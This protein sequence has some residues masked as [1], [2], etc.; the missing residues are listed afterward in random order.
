MSK[1][2]P[3]VVSSEV[4]N[5]FEHKIVFYEKIVHYD[6][7]ETIKSY[8]IE[9]DGKTDLANPTRTSYEK[10]LQRIEVKIKA[11]DHIGDVILQKHVR[12]DIIYDLLVMMFK[13]E[14]ENEYEP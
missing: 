6:D 8:E 5:Q 4:I 10:L 11:L 7:G 12:S 3:H 1:K 14:L 9:Y 2:L 13:L